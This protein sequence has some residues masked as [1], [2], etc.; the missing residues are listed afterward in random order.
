MVVP[1]RLLALSLFTYLALATPISSLDSRDLLVHES[2][3]I[4]PIG[5]SLVGPAPS[6]T[7]LKLR[8]ALSQSNPDSIVAALLNVSDPSSDTYGQH[9]SKSQVEA[10]V[11]PSSQSVSAVKAWLQQHGLTA[12]AASPAGDWLQID[13]DVSKANSLLAADFSTFTHSASGIETVRTLSYSIPAALKDHIDLI[14]PTTAFPEAIKTTGLTKRAIHAPILPRAAD[15]QCANGTT[16]ACLQQLYNIPTT[17]ATNPSNKLAVTGRIGNY[18]HYNW[19]Q[20]F[21]QNFR[22]DM[23]SATNF[24]VTSVDGGQNH[25]TGPSVSEGE[26]DIQYTVGIATNVPVDYVVIGRNW[27]D[28]G[29]N[30]YLDEIN[31][32]LSLEHPPQVLSTSY[33][34]AETSMSYALTDKLCK[35]YAQLGARGVSILFASGDSGVGC[36]NSNATLFEPTFPSNCPWVTS[37]GG[38]A[39]HAPEIAWDGSSGGFSNYYPAPSYQASAVDNFLTAHAASANFNATKGKYNPVG[40]GFPDIAAKADDYRIWEGEVASIYGTSASTPVFASIVALINDCLSVRGKPPMGFLNPWL[41]ST[42]KGAFTDITAGNNS[43]ECNGETAGFEAIE[44]WDPVTGLG[45]PD[46]NKLLTAAGL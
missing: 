12:T 11:A 36:Q 16:P 8:I 42:G 3:E 15:T 34:Y 1:T 44:G 24:T 39:G 17:P 20:S 9:L 41:Y 6:Q 26:L 40:R 37:V 28:D 45:T 27:T 32:L 22:P 19:L 23:D 7:P 33:G 43:I 35:A 29:L 18:A 30:G 13:T 5:F 14:H 38:T 31:Y 46:F 10:L 4:L 25:Q 21:L 2:R